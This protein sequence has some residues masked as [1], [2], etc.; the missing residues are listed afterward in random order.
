MEQPHILWISTHDIG[1]HLGCYRDVWPGAEEAHTPNLDALAA[2]GVRFDQA[3]AA[4][5]VCGPSRS[6][7]MTGSYPTSIGTMHMRSKAVLPPQVRLLSEILRTEGYYTTNNWFTDFQVDTPPIAFDECSPTAHWRNRP[8]DG[9]PFF[10][11]FHGMTTHE[12]RLYYD[13]ESF[14]AAIPHVDPDERHDPAS[15]AVPPYH[16]DTEVFRST[17]ARYHD[18]ITEMDHWVG[19]ILRELDESGLADSTIVVFW[20]DH[21]PGMPRGKRWPNEAGLRVPLIVRWP[22][23]LPAAERRTEV[24]ELLDLAPTLLALAGAEIPAHMHGE[25]L[26][27]DN[28]A[29]TRTRPYAFGG[30][31]RM[32]EQVDTSRTV[33]DERFRYVRHMHPDRSPMQYNEYADRTTTWQE[34]RA[35]AAAEGRQLAAGEEPGILTPLQRTVVAAS[36]PA[37][38]LYD[39]AADPHEEHDIATDPQFEGDL[40]RLRVA[41]DA[42][43]HDA[44]IHDR[45]DLGAVPEIDLIRAWRPGGSVPQTSAPTVEWTEHALQLTCETDGARIGWTTDPPTAARPATALETVSGSPPQDGRHWHV[46][47]ESFPPPADRVWAAAWR[48]GYAPSDEI[49]L[50][51]KET[52]HDR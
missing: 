17:W 49:E 18:L 15:V 34:L 46:Y 30:R 51:S 23:R 14:E 50:T 32:D 22:G 45:G 31:D 38:Q 26:F 48:L 29:F 52:A 10:A 13:A 47:T 4:A 21:G 40:A 1:P 37:E 5:P 16:A 28:G 11:A 25:P 36:K 41:L 20:S 33:R 43:I 3:F 12:S 24:V 42:W 44:S 39:I 8:D 27:D 35:L 7:I 19:G 2:E 9:T 6:A